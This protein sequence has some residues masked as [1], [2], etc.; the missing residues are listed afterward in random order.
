VDFPNS[1]WLGLLGLKMPSS[2]SFSLLASAVVG[3]ASVS[4]T[5]SVRIGSFYSW[6]TNPERFIISAMG[7]VSEVPA[8]SP[9]RA[10]L[11]VDLTLAISVFSLSQMK[12]HLND[13]TF[14]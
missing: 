4:T 8:S 2:S 10:T 5:S 14:V 3:S 6:T 13:G 7:A 9:S 11:A 1:I 12:L